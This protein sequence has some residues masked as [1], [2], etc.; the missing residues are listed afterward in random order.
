[1]ADKT[2]LL[3]ERIR[4]E[5]DRQKTLPGSEFDEKNTVNDWIAIAGHYL[6]EPAKRKS[7]ASFNRGAMP[8]Q[9]DYQ[10]SLIKAAAVIL[11]A[12]E[13][14]DQLVSSGDLQ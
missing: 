6:N 11:A 5:R 10:S 9:A 3:L 13:H 7:S 8:T 4:H 1:M 12:L 2:A 14:T